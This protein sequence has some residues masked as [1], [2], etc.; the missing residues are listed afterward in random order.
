MK[1]VEIKARV[2]DLG[3][4]KSKVETLGEA[5][6]VA[7]LRQIDTYFKVTHGRLKLREISGTETLS[8]LIY[9]VRPDLAGPKTSTYEITDVTDSDVVKRILDGALGILA[10]VSKQRE[11]F[12]WKN[13][14]IH[15]DEVV[16][17]G[18]YVELEAVL[19]RNSSE[20]DGELLVGELMD[21]LRLDPSDLIDSS[22]CDML[23]DETGD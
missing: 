18:D 3:A 17:L 9:Y 16:G 23:S 6:H 20:F 5:V 2:S 19:D 11:L 22:Y 13:V 15:L 21:R 1:N 12:L 10:V 4:V 8:Q 7:S 14:R